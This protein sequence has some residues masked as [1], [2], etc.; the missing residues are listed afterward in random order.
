MAGLFGLSVNHESIRAFASVE[1]FFKETLFWGASYG[2]HLGGEFSG[3]SALRSSEIVT[4]SMSGLLAPNFKHIMDKFI[5]TEAIGCCG[6]AKEP[7]HVKKS[8]IG[9]FSLCFCGNIINLLELEEGLIREAP[10]DR[11]DDIEV[12][13]RL[14][15]KGANIVDGIRRMNQKIRGAYSLL[16][17]SPEGIYAVR[18]PDG[19][20]PLVIGR[21]EKKNIIIVASECVGFNNLGF[22]RV[23]DVNPGEIILLKDGQYL[24]KS[25]ASKAQVKECAFY[26][27]YT[28]SSSAVVHNLPATLIRRKLGANLAKQ[29]IAKGFIPHI[30][31]GV[32]DSGRSHTL[33]YKEAFDTEINRQIGSSNIIL[34]WVPFYRE[35]LIKYFK[36]RSYLAPTQA[37]RDEKAHYKIVITSETV[38]HF[39][40]M[41]REEKQVAILEDIKSRGYI[42]I[43]VCDDSVVRGSQIKSNLAPKIRTIYFE[44]E[45]DGIN[46]KVEIHLRISFPPLFSYCPYGKTTKKGETL[47]ERVP[48]NQDRIKELGVNGLEY[49]S[50]DDLVTILGRPREELCIDCCLPGE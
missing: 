9:P 4:E 15:A 5:G 19:R 35:D 44:K 23:R 49:N 37:E 6:S 3:L 27:V 50:K 43:I 33:G 1:A 46:I 21:H 14:I 12:M 48:E 18:S 40:Q 30:I 11:G 17:L 29:D 26:G 42:I 31:M 7:F 45:L 28:S 22:E 41:L 24:E 38:E 25:E 20:W 36:V 47:A 34:K 8:Q 10:L 32:P 13:S 16:V 39:F 2:Q